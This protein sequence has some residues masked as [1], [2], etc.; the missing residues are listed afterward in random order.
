MTIKKYIILLIFILAISE[1]Q[2]QDYLI[3]FTGSGLSLTVDSVIVENL[4][5]GTSIILSGS[6]TLYL[7]ST[8][9]GINIK[10]ET[11]NNNLHIYP[12]PLTIY[13]NIDFKTFAPGKANI[14]LQDITGKKIVQ[15]YSYLQ[16]G[17]HSFRISDLNPGLYTIMVNSD[18]YS[19]SGIILCN[20]TEK[21][22]GKISYTG[23]NESTR[24]LS[25][26]KSDNEEIVMLYEIGERLK[27]KGITGKYSSI[28]TDIP[29]V[30]KTINFNFVECTDGDDNN[31][32]TVLIG[33]QIWMAE[34]LKA[35]HY[36]DGSEIIVTESDSLWNE[37]AYYDK[38]CCYFNNLSLN[39]EIYGVLYS[40][41]A[42]MNGQN[43][44]NEKPSGIQGACPN[45]WHLPSDAEWEKLI[46]YLGRNEVAGGKI[47]EA[48]TAHWELQNIDATNETG[49]TALPGGYRDYHGR[50]LYVGKFAIFWSSTQTSSIAYA[51]YQK[52]SAAD[53]IIY[54]SYDSKAEGYSVRCVRD[55]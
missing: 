47:K 34:N 2:A 52:L 3:N 21:G 32:P 41:V 35:T 40:W 43:S 30:S 1:L 13:T 11:D 50:F 15:L 7:K 37:L 55:Y 14:T 42:A 24:P 12:N 28:I 38:T 27:F 54:R 19:Y 20:N 46:N 26:L 39:G 9:S 29:E 49:F 22:P 8:L 18:S 25:R 45:S 33:N 16:K 4:T 17:N 5:Q 51:Y 53:G 6:N 48:G 44:S 23:S 10:R 31:Y 36:S